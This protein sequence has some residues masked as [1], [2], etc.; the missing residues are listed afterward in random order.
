MKYYIFCLKKKS[1]LVVHVIIFV[2]LLENM[3]LYYFKAL[4]VDL[5]A[6]FFSLLLDQIKYVNFFSMHLCANE[7]LHSDC[8]AK[9]GKSIGKL[10]GGFLQIF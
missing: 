2:I 3:S 5:F 4:L 1:V 8:M 6:L 9:V 10:F 7:R